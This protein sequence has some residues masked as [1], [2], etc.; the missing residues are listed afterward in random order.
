MC[1]QD[2]VTLLPVFVP[3][4]CFNDVGLLVEEYVEILS[5]LI[6]LLV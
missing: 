4:R 2:S 3:R 5:L 6:T 1:F